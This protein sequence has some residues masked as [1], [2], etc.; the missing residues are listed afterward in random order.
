MNHIIHNESL[1][2]SDLDIQSRSLFFVYRSF[3]VENKFL[4]NKWRVRFV[5][6]THLGFTGFACHS[7]SRISTTQARDSREGM[8]EKEWPKCEAEKGALCLIWWH[9]VRPIRGF[10][11]SLSFCGLKYNL[12]YLSFLRSEESLPIRRDSE[13][14]LSEVKDLARNDKFYL[15]H[16]GRREPLFFKEV[17]VMPCWGVAFSGCNY[18]LLPVERM[19]PLPSA[20]ADT[21]KSTELVRPYIAVLNQS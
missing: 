9:L 18:R 12:K 3:T 5:P 2:E 10:F 21:L 7:L 16:S 15:T 11:G 13:L 20:K 6:G 14:Y 1:R 4:R 8:T 17:P 19:S